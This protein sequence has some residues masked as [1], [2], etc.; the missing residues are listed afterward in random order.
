[1]LNNL[2][3]CGKIILK[4]NCLSNRFH[5][6]SNTLNSIIRQVFD[7]STSYNRAFGKLRGLIESFLIANSKTD[8]LRIFEVHIGNAFGV[9][10]LSSSLMVLYPE[11]KCLA[12]FSVTIN[13]I[14]IKQTHSD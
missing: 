2:R 12:L 4:R 1:M 3:I 5:K 10:F 11:S 9:V 14:A 6:L 8:N 13:P 7:K